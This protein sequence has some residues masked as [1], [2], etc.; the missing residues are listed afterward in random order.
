LDDHAVLK[1]LCGAFGVEADDDFIAE[2]LR[3][4]TPKST[5][6]IAELMQQYEQIAESIAAASNSD[7]KQFIDLA[8]VLPIE[9][10][11]V[12]IIENGIVWMRPTKIAGDGVLIFKS[13]SIGVPIGFEGRYLDLGNGDVLDTQ[14]GKMCKHCG[15]RYLDL[16]D[17]T[18]VDIRTGLQWMRCSLGQTWNGTTCSGRASNYDQYDAKRAIEKLN[19]DGGYAGQRDWRLP[20]LQELKSLVYCSSGQ[21]KKWNDTDDSCKGDYAHPTIDLVA[22][23]MSDDYFWSSS[24]GTRSGGVFGTKAESGGWQVWFHSGHASVEEDGDNNG[25]VRPVRGGQ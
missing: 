24:R 9:S 4:P 21:P 8:D 6:T 5:P 14:T 18:V 13:C 3:D 16:G 12:K 15:Q 1:G 11:A 10:G 25:Y 23:P 7:N 22:F 17:G 2:V 19:R 20:S